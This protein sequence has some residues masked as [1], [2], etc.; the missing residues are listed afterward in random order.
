[1]SV[2]VQSFYRADGKLAHSRIMWIRLELIHDVR[3]SIDPHGLKLEEISDQVD[4]INVAK[5]LAKS[6]ELPS[7]EEIDA[8][9]AANFDKE[10]DKETFRQF[11]DSN[12]SSRRFYM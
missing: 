10:K 6:E 2:A 3:R 7:Q 9:A 4:N 1:M 11:V 5:L 8:Y 12:E